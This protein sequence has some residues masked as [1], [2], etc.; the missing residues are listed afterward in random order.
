MAQPSRAR[1]ISTR[2]WKQKADQYYEL[3][4]DNSYEVIYTIENT[5]TDDFY[6]YVELNDSVGTMF[7][8]DDF[9]E[10]DANGEVISL[11][12]GESKDLETHHL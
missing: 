4:A 1:A 10:E 6:G 2:I 12:P 5:G 7:T 3:K 8:M 9:E 11:K